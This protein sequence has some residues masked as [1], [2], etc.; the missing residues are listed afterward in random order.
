MIRVTRALKFFLACTIF[1][2]A[3]L[4]LAQPLPAPLRRTMD[5]DSAGQALTFV[6]LQSDEERKFYWKDTVQKEGYLQVE[7]S[8]D[9]LSLIESL[10]KNKPSGGNTSNLNLLERCTIGSGFERLQAVRESA[11]R[12]DFIFQRESALAM[13]TRWDFAA[14]AA[15]IVVVRDFVNAKV[16][17]FPGTISLA[18]SAAMPSKG[19]WKLTWYE[20][21][22]QYELYVQTKIGETNIPMTSPENIFTLSQQ[23]VCSK[24]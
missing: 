5:A 23:S 16:K 12:A 1:S 24:N 6:T 9:Y 4:L 2:Q 22:T 21:K 13:L 18:V 19:L 14:D 17:S 15:R 8:L 11:N 3:P 10:I 7:T 20:D